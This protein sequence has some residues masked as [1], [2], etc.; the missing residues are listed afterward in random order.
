M[1]VPFE[2]ELLCR[3]PEKSREPSVLFL[4]IVGMTTLSKSPLHVAREALAVATKALH[5]YAHKFSPKLYTQ[6]QLFTCLVLKTF[7][8]TDYRG[9]TA[10][11]RDSTELRRAIGLRC[12]PHFTTLQKASRRLLRLPRA[13]R[14][15]ATTI[16]RHL[17]RRRRVR[18]AAFDS[19]GLDCGHRS[20]YY[21]RR[22]S[23]TSKRWQRLTYRR[24]AKLELAVDTVNHV[25]LA[26][27]TGRGP[28]P[29]TD[30]YVPLL[31]ATL[32]NVR[33]DATVTDAGYDSEPNHR[34]ARE[35]QGVRSY[36]PATIGRPTA[37]LPSGRY[38]RQM[39]QRLN[40]AYG[41]YGQRWQVECTHSMLKRRLT[42]TV[43]ARSYWGQCRELLLIVLT[44][45]CML[46]VTP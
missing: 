31:K 23:A 27:L 32:R 36:M 17:G 33:V 12:V 6:P 9:L 29:D 43:A 40:K 16:R 11:L 38:R 42:T 39:K 30:R 28:R 35:Q 45:Q 44:Y 34:F 26:A 19:T 7:Y 18:R 46:V 20:S 5:L 41:G 1:S 15:L 22:R 24:Y 3:K 21:V 25:I 4:R 8:K 2:P 10:Q 13:R 37:K 14:L